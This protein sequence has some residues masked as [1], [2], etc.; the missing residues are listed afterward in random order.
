MKSLR[1]KIAGHAVSLVAAV[2]LGGFVSATL[3]RLAP[4]F[5]ADER[6]LDPHLNAQ[7]LQA[8]RD[9]HRQD[10]NIFRFYVAYMERAVHG[11]LGT[12]LALGQPVRVLLH[13]RIPLTLRLLSTGLGLA[14]ILALALSLSAAWLRFSVYDTLT[15]M[16]SG[17]LLCIPAAVL[18]LLSVVWNVPGSLAIAMIV[19]P[20]SFRY[21]R[22]L[23]VKAYSRPHILAARAKGLGEGRILLWHVAPVA[24]PQ[25]MAV[26]GVSVSIAIGAT[27][28]VE[29]LCGLP[30]IGQLAWQ[31]A[32]AR[33]LPLLVNITILVTVVT[34]LAN[35]TADVIGQIARGQEA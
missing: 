21:A 12:S 19:F 15:T 30:G 34:L 16:A 27:I 11:D 10:H 3:V 28:P 26:A 5:D 13:D 17:T 32:L 4:G 29:A 1:W 24:M 35:S 2:L 6:E 8:L 20:H 7:S 31:A 9:Q 33:D 25:L 14:W 22:N 23:L 18:A